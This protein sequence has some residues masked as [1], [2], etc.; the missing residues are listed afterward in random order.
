[1]VE[2][3][4]VIEEC[5]IGWVKDKIRL[6]KQNEAGKICVENGVGEMD[7]CVCEKR[8]LVPLI[9]PLRGISQ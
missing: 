7:V 9:R 4:G 3:R 8:C 6:L 1:M 5:K 2:S